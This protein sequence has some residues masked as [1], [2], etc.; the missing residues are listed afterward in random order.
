[1]RNLVDLKITSSV[2]PY[3]VPK[4]WVVGVDQCTSWTSVQ[5]RRRMSG[6]SS[7][8]HCRMSVE[9][10]TSCI[11]GCPGRI[12]SFGVSS[13]V[14]DWTREGKVRV[15][16]SSH[17]SPLV[18]PGVGT[19]TPD[20]REYRETRTFLRFSQYLGR[21]FQC[22]SRNVE[23]FLGFLN[24]TW[25]LTG[26]T[27]YSTGTFRRDYGSSTKKESRSLCSVEKGHIPGESECVG[28]GQETRSIAGVL[29]LSLRSG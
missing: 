3:W 9:H 2:G 15:V 5:V 17:E 27:V 19:T 1:M 10:V 21:G 20:V 14:T 24:Y 11:S 29:L 28:K 22:H 7:V 13:T 6:I 23:K 16:V 26:V 12:V 4:D 18:T 8:S 25:L